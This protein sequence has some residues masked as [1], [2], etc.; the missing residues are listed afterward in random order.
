M[1]I[2]VRN[3]DAVHYSE[4][5]PS[6][7]LFRGF[8]QFW[9]KC[10]L[11]Q[12]RDIW[13]ERSIACS[14]RVF[15]YRPLACAFSVSDRQR[16]HVYSEISVLA[17]GT[18]YPSARKN[19]RPVTRVLAR[20]FLSVTAIRTCRVITLGRIEKLRLDKHVTQNRVLLSAKLDRV[21]GSTSWSPI[22]V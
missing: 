12:H 21:C 19:V 6:Q 1:T 4:N 9:K 7:I 13:R 22:V 16:W 18:P 15:K 14:P 8:R 2:V 10:C 17:C 3:C 5:L 11:K 20:T